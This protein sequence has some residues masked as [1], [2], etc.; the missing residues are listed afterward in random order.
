[1]GAKYRHK[2]FYFIYI[3][4]RSIYKR[5]VKLQVKLLI[6]LN[7]KYL[8]TKFKILAERNGNKYVKGKDNLYLYNILRVRYTIF[9]GVWGAFKLENSSWK[10]VDRRLK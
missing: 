8:C 3:L 4:K 5:K 7:C 1:M 9:D 10:C 6:S 2:Y